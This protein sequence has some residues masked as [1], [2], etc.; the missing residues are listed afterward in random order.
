MK[1]SD[2]KVIG[3][4]WNMRFEYADN[5]L[6]PCNYKAKYHIV[7]TQ[8]NGRVTEI[9][10]CGIHRNARK[11]HCGDVGIDYQEKIIDS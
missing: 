3:I 4:K 9:D 10:V 1:C 8:K 6:G 5:I 11:K 7:M 2:Q